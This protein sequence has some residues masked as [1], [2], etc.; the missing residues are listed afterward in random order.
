MGCSQS[1]W[2]VVDDPQE[3]S[4]YH[5]VHFD[6]GNG[7]TG[8]F[9]AVKISGLAVDDYIYTCFR[10]DGE[11]PPFAGSNHSNGDKVTT[12]DGGPE[13]Y[14]GGSEVWYKIELS[15]GE[16]IDVPENQLLPARHSSGTWTDTQ[17]K[18]LTT[19]LS[20]CIIDINT[21]NLN[22]KPITDITSYVP[23]GV[24][25]EIWHPIFDDMQVS[26]YYPAAAGNQSGIGIM[27][28]TC[29]GEFPP[30]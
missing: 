24:D 18:D 1:Q 9:E 11:D 22:K 2:G 7:T 6:G 16:Y 26:R 28:A 17:A 23:G 3:S 19:S 10:D 5:T 12:M 25:G 30:L 8:N 21:M 14:G 27:V 4:V 13:G 29:E 15:N 20:L